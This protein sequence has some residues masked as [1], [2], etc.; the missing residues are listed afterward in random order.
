MKSK[1]LLFSIAVIGAI[2]LLLLGIFFGLSAVSERNA[3]AEQ[4]AMMAVLLPGS[5]QFTPEPYVGEDPFISTVWKGEGGFVIETVTTGYVDD[6]TMLVGVNT[7]GKVTGLVVRQMRE[8]YGLGR[9]AL[10]DNAFLTQF[11]GTGGE[12]AVG[13]TIDVLAGATVTSKA[14]TWGVNSAVAFVTGADITSGAT[15]WGG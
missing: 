3:M 5:T 9:N 6:I 11:L 15:T 8:T 13:D 14:I 10:T 4:Q 1:S 2:S 7:A 12:A